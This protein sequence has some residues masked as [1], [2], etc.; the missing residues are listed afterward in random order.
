MTTTAWDA[1]IDDVSATESFEQHRRMLFG[2]AYRMLGSRAEAEDIVQEAF[3]RWS[4]ARP[5]ELR[6]ERAFLTTIVTRLCLDHL[7]SARVKRE[8]YVGPWLPEPVRTTDEADA[9]DIAESI[10]LAFLV[11]LESLTPAERAVY[12]L[13]QVF[14]YSHAEIAA[15]VGRDEVACRQLLKRAR[16]QVATNRPRFAPSR[17]AHRALLGTF[18]AACTAGDLEGLTRLLAE[19]VTAWSDGGGK[20]TAA[21]RVLHGPAMVARAYIGIFAK[22]PRYATAEIA[23]INGWPALVARIDGRIA[24]VITIETDGQRIF[25]VRTIVNPDKLAG[26]A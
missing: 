13:A 14:D 3:L 12:L 19:D 7:K 23:D 17:D 24:S 22:A 4:A 20:A 26:L 11:M 16:E 21:R 2:I 6:S 18:V 1:I 9:V 15:I 10:S 25:A 8:Q 5:D